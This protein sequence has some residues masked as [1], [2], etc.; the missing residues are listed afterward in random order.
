MMQPRVC[1]GETGRGGVERSMQG[2]DGEGG[3]EGGREVGIK[4]GRVCVVQ[5]ASY[6]HEVTVAARAMPLVPSPSWR[7]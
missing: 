1:V 5:S 6:S 7:E 4:A 2:K 3:R